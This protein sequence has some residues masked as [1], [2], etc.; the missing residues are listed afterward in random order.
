MVRASRIS[1]K[2]QVP[3]VGQNVK[4]AVSAK[5]YNS[6]VLEISVNVTDARF[7]F[8]FRPNIP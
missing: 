7:Y 3:A 2:I 1:L 4:D 5:R 8:S 6:Y